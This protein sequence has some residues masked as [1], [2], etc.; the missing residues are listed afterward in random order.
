[1]VVMPT[2]AVDDADVV[3]NPYGADPRMTQNWPYAFL[4]LSKDLIEMGGQSS[5]TVPVVDLKR[6]AEPLALLMQNSMQ[7]MENNDNIQTLTEDLNAIAQIILADQSMNR[8]EYMKKVLSESKNEA[9]EA[10]NCSRFTK[11]IWSDQNA[12]IL[13][14]L[15]EQVNNACR[16]FETA[17]G[18]ATDRM[19]DKI[20]TELSH[21]MQACNTLREQFSSKK[22]PSAKALRNFTM[23]GINDT[24]SS[25]KSGVLP[26]TRAALLQE[27]EDWADGWCDDLKEKPVYILSGAAG[28]GKSTIAY[29]MARR[30]DERHLLGASFFF[31]RGAEDLNSTRLFFSTIV[32]QLALFNAVFCD[33]ILAAAKSHVA[34][35]TQ[36][37]ELV[38][39][40][41]ITEPLN[42]IPDPQS[43]SPIVI[44]IDAVDECTD[45]AQES[46]YRTC[47]TSF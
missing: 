39:D 46:A 12:K 16:K 44:V 6:V 37:M 42:K 14:D 45:E 43:I 47:Y 4:G 25:S 21:M 34:H 29:E 40:E 28:M 35:G 7:M 2:S 41:L 10:E 17:R 5:D 23:N 13:E 3:N 9:R 27:L 31:L 32:Y 8:I 24:W 18:I 38:V 22:L 26:G 33:Y 15:K 20:A 36:R 1:M 30:L 19:V 11:L